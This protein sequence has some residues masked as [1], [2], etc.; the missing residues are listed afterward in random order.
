MLRFRPGDL[1]VVNVLQL[2]TRN[3]DGHGLGDLDRNG[4]DRNDCGKRI[5]RERLD[6]GR[7]DLDLRFGYASWLG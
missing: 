4:L 6:R 2:L 5:G 3:D 1:R 7:G